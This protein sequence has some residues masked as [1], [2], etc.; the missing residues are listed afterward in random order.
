MN[1]KMK[2]ILIISLMGNLFIFYVAYKALSYRA[3][4]NYYLDKYTNVVSEFSGRHV[5]SE[6][7][8][9]LSADQQ[10]DNRIVFFG[11]QITHG[12]ELDKYFPDFE[13]INR[14]IPGQRISGFLLRFKPDVVDLRPKAVIIEFSSYNFRPE[15]T[16]KEIED[17]ISGM[18]DIARMHRIEPILTS[19][20]P[21]GRDF[22]AEMELPYS[23]L[24]SLREFNS[25]LQGYCRDNNLK[26]IDFYTIVA[27]SEGYF[28][29]EFMGG[30]ILL[31]ETGYDKISM[32]ILNTLT[33]LKE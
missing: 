10:I 30:Q 11:S 6:D 20:I 8:N 17:Y 14:G 28:S 5:Y 2:V 22:D 26:F 33:E 16:I 4:I 25:W 21:V 29:G 13:A 9:R 23:V 1:K 18:A 19:V 24:D 27:D 12:W 31:N 32:A 7:N 15:S 3:H